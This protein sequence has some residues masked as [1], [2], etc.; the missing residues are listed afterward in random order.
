MVLGVDIVVLQWW[1]WALMS[2]PRARMG[3]LATRGYDE[4][5]V[6]HLFQRK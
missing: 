6:L 1:R 3:N 2:D 5:S 4:R